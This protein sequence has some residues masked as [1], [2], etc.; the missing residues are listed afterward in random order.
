MT[1]E[2]IQK[3]IFTNSSELV[4]RLGVAIV[5]LAKKSI[6]DHGQF[7]IAL[8]GGSTPKRLYQH[9]VT[10]KTQIDWSRTLI[11][12]S[13]ERF[14][15]ANSNLSNYY[16]ASESLLGR[17]P[18]PSANIFAV[19]T[20][21]PSAEESAIQYEITIRK[22][23]S[24]QI[25]KRPCLDLILLGVGEDGHTASLFPDSK[26]LANHVDLVTHD[27]HQQTDTERVTFTLELINNADHIFVI[28]CG[29]SKRDIVDQVLIKP[30]HPGKL[31]PIEQVLAREST[32]WYMDSLAYVEN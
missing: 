16:M 3:S 1:K 23:I 29:K 19:D 15:N 7:S 4:K 13:D 24:T 31:Y 14:V 30:T 10:L 26:A 28:V 22:N 21:L 27:Y 5:D 25:N 18:I 8:S 11:F 2:S 12:F 9:L 17:I 32:V 6:A 20:S